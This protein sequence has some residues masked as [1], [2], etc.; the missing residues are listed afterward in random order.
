MAKILFVDDDITNLQLMTRLAA[1]IDHEA[2]TTTKAEEG[3]V[4]AASHSPSVIFVDRQLQ[5]LDGFTFIQRVRSD[6]LLCHIPCIMLSAEKT[7]EE[8][9]KARRAGAN[10]FFLKPVSM[11]E[12]K[13]IVRHFLAKE[14]APTQ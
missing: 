2:V 4:L 13:R 7:V 1:F 3:L 12:L 11:D 6:T 10:G 5:G 8:V 9:Q 14:E